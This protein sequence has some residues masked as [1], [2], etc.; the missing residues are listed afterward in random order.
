MAPFLGYLWSVARIFI[1]APSGRSRFNVLGALDAITKELIVVSNDTYINSESIIQ[2]L[3]QLAEKIP[4]T[5]IPV[6]LIMDN[7]RYQ[8]C[9][10]V[11]EAA[12]ILDIDLVFL[13]PYSPN[14]NLIERLW[15]YV[16][17]SCL[18]SKY[19][20]TFIEFKR[21]ISDCLD[22][23]NSECNNE[24]QSLLSLNFQTFKESQI[25]P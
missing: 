13:P 11:Q 15:K 16:K 2:L 21:A 10:V 7:A 19:Y 9:Q 17:K 22:K 18:Y 25:M 3:Y 24:I 20:D 12:E 4:D 5:S 6:T 8:K 14:L 23:I 1:K